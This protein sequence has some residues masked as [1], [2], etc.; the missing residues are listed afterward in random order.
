V[1][2]KVRTLPWLRLGVITL[3]LYIVTIAVYFMCF[4]KPVEYLNP[5]PGYEAINEINELYKSMKRE[6]IIFVLVISF[7][8][9]FLVSMVISVIYEEIVMY[10]KPIITVKAK[11]KSKEVDM[12]ISGNYRGYSSVGF[13]YSLTFELDNREEIS[14]FVIPKYY[15]TIIEGN[16]GNL[17][18]KQG[19]FNRFVDFELTEIE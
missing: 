9:C 6:E 2:N 3:I 15:A 13:I 4:Y 1:S 11:L 7:L 19:S 8:F 12:K 18:Y 10:T 5:I 16:K 14:F 17:K